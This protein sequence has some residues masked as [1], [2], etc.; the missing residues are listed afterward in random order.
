V[1][2]CDL[3]AMSVGVVAVSDQVKVLLEASRDARRLEGAIAALE[4]GMTGYGNGGHPFD[5][6]RRRLGQSPG[7]RYAVV[8]A[9]GVWADQPAAVRAARLC[10]AAEIEVIGVGFGSADETFLRD[11]SSGDRGIFT[12]LGRL[13][14]TFSSIA[15]ELG[16]GRLQ[17]VG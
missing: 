9:D 2:E 5:E 10:H 14:E 11:I 13:S 3:E 8:L 15:Q 16:G 17:R 1:E 7:G 6:L 12:D 4:A